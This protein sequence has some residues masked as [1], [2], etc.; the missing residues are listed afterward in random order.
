MLIIVIQ[1]NLTNFL[2]RLI[3]FITISPYLHKSAD[4]WKYTLA[5]FKLKDI[6]LDEITVKYETIMVFVPGTRMDRLWSLL[7][8]NLN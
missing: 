6:L 2:H 4:R 5:Y 7:H 1:E 8:F 3:K